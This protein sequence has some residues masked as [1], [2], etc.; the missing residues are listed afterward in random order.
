MSGRF[1][2]KVAVTVFSLEHGLGGFSRI[3]FNIKN[4]CERS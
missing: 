4:S 3:S 2:L 1:W